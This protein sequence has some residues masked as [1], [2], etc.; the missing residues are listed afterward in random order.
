[1]FPL[2]PTAA[3]LAALTTDKTP[4]DLIWFPPIQSNARADRTAASH[5]L[6]TASSWP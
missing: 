1:M 3:D 6:F 2:L 5:S 4:A